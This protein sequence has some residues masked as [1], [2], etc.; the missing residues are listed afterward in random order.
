MLSRSPSRGSGSAALNTTV[1]QFFVKCTWYGTNPA[2]DFVKNF[3]ALLCGIKP[4]RCIFHRPLSTRKMRKKW[5]ACQL[6][7]ERAVRFKVLAGEGGLRL[8]ATV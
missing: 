1:Q 2:A 6:S 4:S 7:A 5:K 3:A 8:T